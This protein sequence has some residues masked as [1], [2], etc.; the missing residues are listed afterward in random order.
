MVFEIG[1]SM[2][3]EGAETLNVPKDERKGPEKDPLERKRLAERLKQEM[4]LG[5]MMGGK[6]LSAAI[7]KAREKIGAFSR[8]FSSDKPP[9]ER[10]VESLQES[11]EVEAESSVDGWEPASVSEWLDRQKNAVKVAWEGL[12]SE[13]AA[14]RLDWEGVE[15]DGGNEAYIINVLRNDNGA[16]LSGI[17]MENVRFYITASSGTQDR[18][19]ELPF[20]QDGRVTIPKDS[21]LGKVLF[22]CR[23]GGGEFL[24]K[25][26]AVAEMVGWGENGVSRLKKLGSMDRGGD[27]LDRSPVA[28]GHSI[29]G[30]APVVE[31]TFPTASQEVIPGGSESPR[32]P[33]RKQEARPNFAWQLLGLDLK[34]VRLERENEEV[35]RRAIADSAKETFRRLAKERRD[36]PLAGVIRREILSMPGIRFEDE[37]NFEGVVLD[38]DFWKAFEGR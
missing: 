23:H 1:K 24:G 14:F 17:D 29:D 18:A 9:M 12:D 27:T 31:E 5:Q 22:A 25:S 21:E 13:R 20:P 6:I 7:R 38:E 36:G 33:E 15:K 35:I 37:K 32:T 34:A 19:L 2:H 8:R 30:D 11:T 10:Q 26:M 3:L 28:V 16:S 4:T